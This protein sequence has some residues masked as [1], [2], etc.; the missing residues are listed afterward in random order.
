MLFRSNLGFLEKAAVRLLFG[1]LPEASLKASINAFEKARVLAPNFVL[2][3]FEMARA[4]KDNGQKAKAIATLNA[5]ML[6]KNSTE[7]D[8]PTK[9]RAKL[10]LKEWM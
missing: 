2:N 4:Y 3:Y 10:L 7:D 9:E 8:A 6:Q 5:M 1:G